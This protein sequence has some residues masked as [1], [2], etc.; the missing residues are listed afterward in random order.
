MKSKALLILLSLVFVLSVSLAGCGGGTETTAPSSDEETTPASNEGTTDKEEAEEPKG[1]TVGGDIIFASIG[2]PT[3][4]NGLYSSDNASSEVISLVFEGLVNS[5]P[6]LAPE[7]ALAERWEIS[8]DGLEYTFYLKKG[9]KFHDGTPMTANDVKFTYSIPLDEDYDGP[10]A[11]DFEK[12]KEFDVIDDHTIK[13]IL[14]E[15]KVDFIWT[16]SYEIL[17]EH[18]L[19][20]VPVAELQN[21]EF[22]RTQ[23]IGTGPFKFVEWVEGQYIKVERNPDYHGDNYLNSVTYK[24]VPDANAVLA[25]LGVGEVNLA[26]VAATDYPTVEEWVNQGKMEIATIPALSYTY[27]GYNLTNPLF[28]DKKVRQAMT[29]ALDRETMIAA[30]MNGRGTVANAPESPVSWA[31]DDSKIPV[32]E[33]DVEKAKSLL[34]EAGWTLGSDGILEKDGQKF[35]FVLMTNQGNAVREQLAVIVQDQL[36]KVGISVTPQIVE[37]SAFISDHVLAKDFEAIILGWSLGVDPDPSGIFH[38]KEIEE[39]MNFISYSRPDLDVLMDEQLTIR[40]R[41]ERKKL[42]AEIDAEIAADQPYSFLY[43]PVDDLAKPTNLVIPV[44]HPK[45][46]FYDVQ[47]WYFE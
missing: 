15:E 19:K 24:I 17:P 11:S 36:K 40:D 22:N 39:G 7:P 1:P 41:D 5:D 28:E 43:Y 25:Q 20:D 2:A 27:L 16:A 46:R 14:S 9:V 29:H 23:P 33:Y 37:W 31:Y 45:N 12:I 26:N 6:S 21:H 3:T 32:F 13:I 8:D 42:I 10:R 35:E 4:F 34:A 47:N 44:L 18:I 30:V 38:T